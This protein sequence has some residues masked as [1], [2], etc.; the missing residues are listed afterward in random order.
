MGL[1]LQNLQLLSHLRYPMDTRQL[2]SPQG[3]ADGVSE[4]EYDVA[5]IGGGEFALRLVPH[6]RAA[7]LYWRLR[8]HT[9][10]HIEELTK[11]NEPRLWNSP[12]AAA[13]ESYIQDTRAK[14]ETPL[15]CRPR[16]SGGVVLQAPGYGGDVI[17]GGH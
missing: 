17:G 12:P 1:S 14:L 10:T 2:T 15:A 16:G 3:E 9:L 4:R 7:P 13:T 5:G 11:A 8:S 6:Q